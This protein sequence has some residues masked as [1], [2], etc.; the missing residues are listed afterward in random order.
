MRNSYGCQLLGECGGVV[1]P[2]SEHTWQDFP[3]V[4]EVEVR[5]E[6]TDPIVLQLGEGKE[7][8]AADK[9]K[10]A[11]KFLNFSFKFAA[12]EIFI[13]YPSGNVKWI[14]ED[15]NLVSGTRGQT[16]ILI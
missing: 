13:R 4:L 11:N 12:S 2:G 10:A 9:E 6:E 3:A 16:E 15:T 14:A 1:R 7:L 8:P 5:N